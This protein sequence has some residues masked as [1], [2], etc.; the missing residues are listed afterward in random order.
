ITIL[1]SGCGPMPNTGNTPP[2]TD[3]PG[4]KEKARSPGA[5]EMV[6][7]TS[8]VAGE[9]IA[10]A[11]PLSVAFALK[12][13][14]PG[15]KLDSVIVNGGSATRLTWLLPSRNS[16]LEMDFPLTAFATADKVI[17]A[18]IAKKLP[19]VGLVSTTVG[20]ELTIVLAGS[21]CAPQNPAAN[22]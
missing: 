7:D 11:P 4:S 2:W 20:T 5:L 15:L 9:E 22:V 12:M 6:P 3:D 1:P 17:G 8:M 21:S 18:P 14:T 16:T 10:E 13:C 19:L